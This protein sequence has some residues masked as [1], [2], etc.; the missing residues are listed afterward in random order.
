[1]PLFAADAGGQAGCVVGQIVNV[2]ALLV[3]P[4]PPPPQFTTHPVGGG[5]AAL[6]TVTVAV[7]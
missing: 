4:P 1:V 2:I 3:P 5:D 6:K 7:F